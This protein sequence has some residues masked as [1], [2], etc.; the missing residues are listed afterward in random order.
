VH[1]AMAADEEKNRQNQQAGAS[2]LDQ[3]NAPNGISN[4]W[5]GDA[6][7]NTCRPLPPDEYGQSRAERRTEKLARHIADKIVLVHLTLQPERQRDCGVDM[8]TTQLAKRRDGYE[9]SA[10]REHQSRNQPAHAAIGKHDC[11]R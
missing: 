6:I 10:S 4:P 8:G 9:R 5:G 1:Q 2:H 3:K 7:M 11:Q